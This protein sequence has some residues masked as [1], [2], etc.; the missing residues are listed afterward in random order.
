M[1]G[2]CGLP[3]GPCGRPQAHW[4]S[5]GTAAAGPPVVIGPA[6][7][8]GPRVRAQ[9]K[10]P[11]SSVRGLHVRQT[12]A[13]LRVRAISEGTGMRTVAGRELR[14]ARSSVREPTPSFR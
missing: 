10:A 11:N 5:T 7:A 2:I 4:L 14:R 13:G 9:V 8:G 1:Q 12:A 6:A 3:R